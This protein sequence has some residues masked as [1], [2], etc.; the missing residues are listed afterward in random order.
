MMEGREDIGES[1]E[2]AA[3]SGS[4]FP[5]VADPFCRILFSMVGGER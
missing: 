3:H 2:P 1:C 4:H 5:N